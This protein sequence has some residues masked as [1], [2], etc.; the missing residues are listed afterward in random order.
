[1]KTRHENESLAGQAA[2]HF[3]ADRNDLTQPGPQRQ[4]LVA[5]A[6]HFAA[7]ATDTFFLVLQDI[8]MTH[9]ILRG[10]LEVPKMPEVPRIPEVVTVPA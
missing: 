8:I 10:F 3:G 5:L 6:M 2:V 7:Q 1:V 4:P 9:E